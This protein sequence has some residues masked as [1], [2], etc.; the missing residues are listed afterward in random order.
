LKFEINLKMKLIKLI[1]RK[2]NNNYYK[3]IIEH[4]FEEVVDDIKTLKKDN[5]YENNVNQIVRYLY[6]NNE[7]LIVKTKEIITDKYK[8]RYCPNSLFEYF[9][10][11]EKLNYLMLRVEIDKILGIKGNT[12]KI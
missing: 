2:L 3:I 6:E 4:F 1:Q 11:S 8:E 10:Q 5:L 7:D 12:Y 9:N